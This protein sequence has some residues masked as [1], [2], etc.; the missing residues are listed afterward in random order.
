MTTEST[1]P[2]KSKVVAGVLGILL[3]T[4]GVHK[5]YLGYVGTG[6]VHVVLTILIITAPVSSIVGLIEGI[7][8][9]TKTD[10]EFHSTYVENRKSW[11]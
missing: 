11:F 4:L 8:Y 5:F 6:I 1:G 9:L 10:S 7:L 2:T 3:G